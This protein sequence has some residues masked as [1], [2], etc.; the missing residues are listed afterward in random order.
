MIRKEENII[1]PIEMILY[2]HFAIFLF[3]SFD[4]PLFAQQASRFVVTMIYAGLVIYIFLIYKIHFSVNLFLASFILL[5][6]IIL[7]SCYSSDFSHELIF[8]VILFLFFITYKIDQDRFIWFIN[9]T[10]I[11]YVII[12]FFLFYISGNVIDPELK[13]M[14]NRFIPGFNRL[15]GVEGSPAGID[16]FSLLVVSLNIIIK[17][18]INAFVIT[19]VIVYI[20]TSSYTPLLALILSLLFTCFFFKFKTIIFII[21]VLFPFIAKGVYNSFNLDAFLIKMTSERIIIW[22]DMINQYFL[23]TL[24]DTL[25]KL[26]NIPEIMYSGSITNNP[27]N[28]TL[29]LMFVSGLIIFSLFLIVTS[30]FVSTIDSKKHLFIILYLILSAQMNRYVLSFYNPVF[31]YTF[32]YFLLYDYKTEIMNHSAYKNYKVFFLLKPSKNGNNE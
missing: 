26:K 11:F 31:I 23:S 22:N 19:G 1:F 3:N 27:H 13:Q 20:L 12:S 30:F 7:A 2:F 25:L 8:F 24:P 17:K 9:V 6:L 14:S 21:I 18:R 15:L 29:Y 5:F 32:F 4:V 28:I 10:Y 16:V